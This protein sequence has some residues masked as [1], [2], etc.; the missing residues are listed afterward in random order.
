MTIVT[1]SPKAKPAVDASKSTPKKRMTLNSREASMS[2]EDVLA[3]RTALE[4]YEQTHTSSEGEEESTVPLKKEID[5]ETTS[6]KR[7]RE[8]GINFTGNH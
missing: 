8:L 4:M 5:T 7:K 3:A 6:L 1:V 2:L